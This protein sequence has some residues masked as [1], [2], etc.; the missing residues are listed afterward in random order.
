[1]LPTSFAP[2]TSLVASSL[3]SQALVVLPDNF[4]TVLDQSQAVGLQKRVDEFS[5]TNMPLNKISTIGL[6]AEVTLSKALDGFLSRIDKNSSPQILKLV[7]ELNT[8]IDK[9]QLMEMADQIMHAKLTL[10]ERIA[11]FFNKKKMAEAMDRAYEATG[12]AISGKTKT[13]ADVVNV[14]ERTLRTE[15]DKVNDEMRQFDLVKDKYR[16]CFMLFAIETAFAN[17]VLQKAKSEA[18]VILATTTDVLVHSDVT[19]K[20]Q[21]LE[22][23]A[24]AIESS[25]TRLPADQ[26]VIRQLQE[27]GV[28]TIQELATTV[29]ARFNDIRGTLLTLHGAYKVQGVQRLGEQGAALSRNLQQVRSSV[30]KEITI[31]AA[32]A[33]GKNR[34]EQAKQLVAVVSDTKELY[35]LVKTAQ[36]TNQTKFD[37]ARALLGQSRQEMLA[38]GSQ[39][40]PSAQYSL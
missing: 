29:T 27:A 26:L 33:P 18:E 25:L 34:E 1:M 20:L 22:S 30:M 7:G 3:A 35:N 19:S 21:A 17:S 39:M 36:A 31:A 40:N 12:R 5:I 10:G 8:A 15:M 13:L 23:R 38:L 11:G 6:E 32:E 37:Q 24:L 28:M 16:E 9:E 14:Q 4:P 2:T